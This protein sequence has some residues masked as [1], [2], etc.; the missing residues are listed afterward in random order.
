M[1]NGQL[2][3]GKQKMIRLDNKDLS[4]ISE[5]LTEAFLNKPPY[6]Q[7]FTEPNHQRLT[8]FFIN[9]LCKYALKYGECYTTTE[10]TGVALWLKPQAP[11]ISFLKACFHGMYAAPIKMGA[12]TFFHFMMFVTHISRRHRKC[13][14]KPHYYLLLIGVS[15]EAAGQ[16]IGTQLLSS[17]LKRAAEEKIAVYV[18]TQ[19]INNLAF[20]QKES[21][22]LI[23]QT[24]IPFVQT[25]SNWGMI[26][27]P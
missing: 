4:W 1:I 12:K 16:G 9:F 2:I 26:K 14:A 19:N 23:E 7:I 8:Y 21:F 15:P 25:L 17:M 24:E 20:Y 27:Q 13:I 5:V 22:K 3:R 11:D 6:N 10:K 18:E